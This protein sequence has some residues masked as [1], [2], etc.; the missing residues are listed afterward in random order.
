M[1]LFQHGVPDFYISKILRPVTFDRCHAWSQGANVERRYVKTAQV[2]YV[3]KDQAHSAPKCK[4]MLLVRASFDVPLLFLRAAA[5]AITWRKNGYA[6]PD[7]FAGEREVVL[8]RMVLM[9][10]EPVLLEFID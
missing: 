3:V 6:L 7:L 4:L 10:G 8:I 2:K 5:M 9:V 1:R